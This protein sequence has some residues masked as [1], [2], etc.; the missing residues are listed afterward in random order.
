MT[1]VLAMIVLAVVVVCAAS[2]A[3][4]IVHQTNPQLDVRI[5]SVADDLQLGRP[6]VVEVD[7]V[8]HT[9]MPVRAVYAVQW[10]S[11]PFIWQ[12]PSDALA[13]ETTTRVRLHTDAYQRMPPLARGEGTSA[14]STIGHS[15]P[16]VV[17]INRSGDD[18]YW[19]S[20]PWTADLPLSPIVNDTFRSWAP[21]PSG[22]LP[23]GWVRAPDA[24]GDVEPVP[25]GGMALAIQ[26]G[27]AGEG[28]QEA[29]LFRMVDDSVPLTALTC[30][31]L[32]AQFA[33]WPEYE[34]NDGVSPAIASGIQL[35]NM[36]RP[37]SQLWVVLNSSV[38]RRSVTPAG[39]LIWQ[40][41]AQPDRPLRLDLEQASE[42]LGGGPSTPLQ[43]KLFVAAY[44]AA[45]AAQRLE[46]NSIGCI[47]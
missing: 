41:A 26:G 3:A 19:V 25:G 43:A 12:G 23:F 22:P 11:Y 9:S 15:V 47:E 4:V 44:G 10:D 5:V 27:G 39:P 42:A 16:F 38:E 37:G 24:P 34:S 40:V 13:P 29:S 46:I 17:K 8:N 21:S 20:G 2:G 35:A 45:A 32:E 30:P 18:R 1:R 28:W 33:R 36:Q 31:H 14:S 6:N 7:V